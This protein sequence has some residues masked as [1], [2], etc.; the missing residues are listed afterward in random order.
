M[1]KNK[2][3]ISLL[4][5]FLG[6][7]LNSQ[8][9]MTLAAPSTVMTQLATA[10]SFSSDI[11]LEQAS[12]N[13]INETTA[14]V[15]NPEAMRESVEADAAAF[16]LK[17]DEA[18]LAALTGEE[19]DG[20]EVLM[21][22]NSGALNDLGGRL[23]LE[24]TLGTYIYD[25]GMMDLTKNTSTVDG[26]AIYNQDDAIFA[27]GE[28][29]QGRVTVYIDFKRQ[30]QWGDMEFNTRLASQS[31]HTN[32]K[33]NG[34]SSIVD[35]IPIDRQLLQVLELQVLEQ[36]GTV[37]ERD[38]TPLG[39]VY[40]LIQYDKHNIVSMVKENGTPATFTSNNYEPY[41]TEDRKNWQ[42]IMSHSGTIS[43][44][45]TTN[46]DG[47]ILLGAQI[48]TGVD[49]STGTLTAMIEASTID[50]NEDATEYIKGIIR[51]DQTVDASIIAV[52][53]PVLAS[54]VDGDASAIDYKAGIIRYDQ[55]VEVKAQIF[56]GDS[57][58]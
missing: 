16:G 2:F 30:V 8:A 51:Y 52:N 21:A 4:V 17:I 40:G 50:G 31:E 9:E 15:V 20:E 42:R 13:I 5:F 26:E 57:S 14:A 25:S 1:K 11:T 37:M 35:S 41:D 29:Q 36:D 33:V 24:P 10:T 47:G 53:V 38:E 3:I 49:A 55:T 34:G 18:A 54:T 23:D 19:L 27:T 48:L 6:F 12:I 7:N 46:S 45:N 58:R 43:Q 32:I 39:A 44:Q 56:A 28:V 22:L